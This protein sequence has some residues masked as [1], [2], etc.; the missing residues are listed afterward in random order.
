VFQGAKIL[1]CPSIFD[2]TGLCSDTSI[3]YHFYLF[4]SS[5]VTQSTLV[6]LA[7][8]PCGETRSTL[9]DFRALFEPDL[10]LMSREGIID[11]KPLSTHSSNWYNRLSRSFRGTG[12]SSWLPSSFLVSCMV[13]WLIHYLDSQHSAKPFFHTG[14]YTNYMHTHFIRYDTIHT[15]IH[16]Y[17]HTYIHTYIHSYILTYTYTSKHTY[18]HTCNIHSYTHAQYITYN[19]V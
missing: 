14:V 18:V 7:P 3:P 11:L 15:Y 10:H 1:L 6:L 5:T 19:Y 16:T 4:I 12:L 8:I 17:M 13:D 2:Q 9:T